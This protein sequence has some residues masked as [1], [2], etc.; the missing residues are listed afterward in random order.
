MFSMDESGWTSLASLPG[1]LLWALLAGL[2]GAGQAPLGVIELLFLFAPLVVVPLA[3]ELVSTVSPPEM[4]SIENAARAM[5]PFAALSVVAAFWRGPGKMAGLLAIPWVVVCGTVALSGVA[6]LRSR[7]S[8]PALLGSV[9]RMDLGLAGGWLLLSRL[10]IHPGFLEPIVLLTAV[11]FHYSGFA[12][13]VIAVAGLE[14]LPASASRRVVWRGVTLAVA[15][16]PFAVAAGFVFSP[17][18]RA[19]S[20]VAFAIAL[21]MLALLLFI[22]SAQFRSATARLF[23]RAA[24]GIVLV[25]MILAATY[26]V[27]ESTH[28]NWLTIPRMAST[29]GW[30]NSLGF[31][32]LALLGWLVE[33]HSPASH[34]DVLGDAIQLRLRATPAGHGGLDHPSF[35][36]RDFYDS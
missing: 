35:V 30:I 29:H 18:L 17:L 8:G 15:F 34:V 13:S 20:A 10:G 3:L 6:G 26:A 7:M 16:L 32:M 28:R 1:A 23:V 24:S 14:S 5:Q 2:A 36:A 19:A 27:G 21:V 25:G 33:L 12:T 4:A 31:V 11:H 22:Q 9:A